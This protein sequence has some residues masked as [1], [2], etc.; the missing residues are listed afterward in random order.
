MKFRLADT[1]RMRGRRFPEGAVPV[2]PQFGIATLGGAPMPGDAGAGDRWAKMAT[3]LLLTAYLFHAGLAV[4]VHRHLYGDAAWYLVRMLSEGNVTS[5]YR[6]LTREF[7]YSRIF[8]YWLTQAPAVLAIHAGVASWQIPSWI[9]GATFFSY[10]LLS[11]VVCYALLPRRRKI[12]VVFPLLGLFAGTINSEIYIVT[13][14]H[15]V[16]AFFWPL[17]IALIE[18]RPAAGWRSVAPIAAAIVLTSLMFEAMAFLAPILLAVVA[19]RFLESKRGE[20]ARLALLM[21]LLTA[22][23]LINWLA[24][25][26][27]R[28]PRNRS[29]FSAGLFKLYHDQGA[30]QTLHI[31]PDVSI[32]ALLLVV[33]NIVLWRNSEAPAVRAVNALGAVTLALAP[34]VHFLATRHFV[35][36]SNAI[37]DRGFGGFLMQLA[38]VVP[39]IACAAFAR[40]DLNRIGSRVVAVVIAL[41]AGQLAWQV[42]ATKAWVENVTMVRYALGSHAGPVLCQALNAEYAAVTTV[43]IDHTLCGWWVTPL[44]LLLSPGRRVESLVVAADTTDFRAFDPLDPKSL[45]SL[46]AYPVDFG[47]YL[48]ALPRAMSIGIGETVSFGFRGRG[49]IF[50]RDGFA[51]PEE[52]GTWTDGDDANMQ[53]CGLGSPAI[54][55]PTSFRF[56]VGAFVSERHP[57][58][59]VTVVASGSAVSHWTISRGDAVEQRV[60]ELP[61]NLPASEGCVRLKFEIHQSASPAALGISGDPRRLGLA[62]VEVS[63]VDRP[64]APPAVVPT[65]R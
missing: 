39:F 40:Y 41:G 21:A 65:L 58:I 32:A 57:R 3:A 22:V 35:D 16:T 62:F 36:F 8:A 11:L 10:K 19:V 31:G 46:R 61:K 24:I 26:L 29:A 2:T 55:V 23:T 38:I 18:M 17:L 25:V 49:F 5:F 63:M 12:L 7:Y 42:L 64:S 34:P 47:G 54:V 50:L 27:P 20:R 14:T 37:S 6:D 56:K 1:R 48:Q 28:D 43:P 33:V 45:P 60:V 44:S 9:Y 51:S 59:D 15:I 53:F 4:L 52:W 30:V 13:E